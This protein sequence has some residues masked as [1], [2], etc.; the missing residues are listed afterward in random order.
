MPNPITNFV[1]KINTQDLWDDELVIKRK[2]YL[3]LQGSI[4]TNLY[5][6][7]TG[8]LRIYVVD[9]FEEHIIRFGYQTNFIA[10]LDSFINEKPSDLYIQAIKK[11]RIKVI[12]KT[13][14][15]NFV[16]SSEE[17]IGIWY[18]MLED[19]IL[20]QM[21]RERDILTSSP[22]ERY[23]RVSVRSPQLF[24]EIPDKYIASYLRMTPETLSRI[25][26]S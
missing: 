12:R 18:L 20:Q 1:K 13:N 25:K 23:R 19:L 11:S 2:E 9:E 21:E 10:A 8:S 17:N 22:L 16:R 24:Q 15:M 26:K 5:Y 4:D 7:T 6:I 14:F 3:K